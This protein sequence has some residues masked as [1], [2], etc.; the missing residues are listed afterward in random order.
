MSG[1]GL[2]RWRPASSS[3]GLRAGSG[4]RAANQGLDSDFCCRIVGE[5]LAYTPVVGCFITDT[6]GM[7]VVV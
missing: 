2:Q 6:R 4:G 5:C 3:R 7:C 1:K